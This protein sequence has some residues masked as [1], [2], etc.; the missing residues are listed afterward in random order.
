MDPAPTLIAEAAAKLAGKMPAANVES[1][2]AAL[3]GGQMT[4]A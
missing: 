2:A 4:K 3:Q 1:R